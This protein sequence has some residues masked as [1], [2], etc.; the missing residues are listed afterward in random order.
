MGEGSVAKER[1]AVAYLPSGSGDKKGADETRLRDTSLDEVLPGFRAWLQNF[2]PV[3]GPTIE[4][5]AQH[6]WVR[7][8]ATMRW[9]AYPQTYPQR[10]TV[11]RRPVADVRG[12]LR[13]LRCSVRA[14]SAGE[15]AGAPYR[16]QAVPGRSDGGIE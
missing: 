8:F 5:D 16:F 2:G 7:Q 4:Q 1:V 9:C 11:G 12:C 14:L 6:S 3:V 15:G 13:R 10:A